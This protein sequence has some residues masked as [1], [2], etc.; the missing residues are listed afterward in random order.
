[1][2]STR[3]AVVIGATGM[4]GKQLVTQLLEQHTYAEVI[5]LVRKPTEMTHPKLKQQVVVNWDELQEYEAVFQQADVLFCCI[6]TTIKKAGSQEAFR[7][8]DLEYPVAAAKIAYRHGVRQFIGIS[9][10]GANSQ[11]RIFYSRTK[12]QFEEEI[13]KIG[14]PGV[15]FVRP[16]LLLGE[17]KERRAGEKFGEVILRWM[18]P[19][20]KLGIGQ[21][22]RA[23]SGTMVARA[24][25]CIAR[26][27]QT[28]V[29]HYSNQQIRKIA[30]ELSQ[31]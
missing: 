11:S 15:H 12:G 18:D 27:D 20:L 30:E 6:G 23:I 10:M 5:I 26:R 4:V 2:E 31:E 25:I 28:G 29:Y 8:V 3:K 22:Y 9:S 21:N 13:A 19:L 24:M 16:S 17:R 1:M 14:I 7:K